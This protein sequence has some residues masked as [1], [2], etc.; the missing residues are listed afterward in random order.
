MSILKVNNLSAGYGK[1][2]ILSS[3]SFQVEAGEFCGIIGANGSGKTTLIKAVCS[4]IPHEGVC[5]VHGAR[6][7]GISS[8]KMAGLCSYIPQRSGISI[9]LS[10]LDVVLMGFNHKLGLLQYPTADM[11]EKARTMLGKVGL[12]G[13]EH[14]N[15]QTFSEGQK[16]L[17][18]LARS[19][20]SDSAVLFMDEPESALD[21][22]LR[23]GMM[24]FV[25]AWVKEKRTC[26][27]VALHDIN[28]ALNDCDKLLLLKDGRLLCTA[29]PGKE[30]VNSLGE[31]LSLIYG[32]VSLHVLFDRAGTQQLVMMKE[33]EEL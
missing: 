6:L 31:K 24:D 7:E 9:D 10:A 12:G 1:K 26:A 8:R 17:C 5:T 29:Q 13:R 21:F 32:P 15:Y 3:I 28:L 27:V 30:S 16:Q 14:E 23:Y 19:L 33:P 11:V 25:R 18:I 4:L 22:R 20:V 2:A